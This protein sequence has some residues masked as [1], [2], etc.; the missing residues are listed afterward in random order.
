MRAIFLSVMPHPYSLMLR[1][2]PRRDGER[3]EATV[4]G[5]D[6]L[7]HLA[8]AQPA[9]DPEPCHARQGERGIGEDQGRKRGRDGARRPHQ[10]GPGEG[11]DQEQGRPDGAAVGV[12]VT[13]GQEEPAEGGKG[14]HQGP[15]I[16]DQGAEREQPHPPEHPHRDRQRVALP[17]TAA[18]EARDQEQREQPQP[19][20]GDVVRRRQVVALGKGVRRGRIRPGQHRERCERPRFQGRT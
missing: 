2:Q 10:F 1:P 11:E 14:F 19:G 18:E 5:E 9:V 16:T 20:A 13:G 8:A 6:E 17:R 4:D 15:E 7:E 12:P 3:G